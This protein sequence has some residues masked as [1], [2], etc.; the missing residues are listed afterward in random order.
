LPELF[1]G[2]EKPAPMNRIA[3][4]PM[5]SY[6]KCTREGFR[7]R[8]AHLLENLLE[9]NKNLHFVSI[10]RPEPLLMRKLLRPDLRFSLNASNFEY[11][12]TYSKKIPKITDRQQWWIKSRDNY[13][14]IDMC[15]YRG[16][17][18][19]NPLLAISNQSKALFNSDKPILFDVLDDWSIH[20]SFTRVRDNIELAYKKIFELS[21]YITANSEATVELS[22]RFGRSDVVLIPNGVEPKNFSTLSRADGNPKVGYI[23]K[24]GSRVDFLSVSEVVI[25]NP[26]VDFWFA[27]PNLGQNEIK[28][29]T[30]H[31]NFKWFGDIHYSEIPKFLEKLDLAWIPH[32]VGD[33]EVG[34]DAI[35]LYEYRAAG[36]PVLTSPI[37]GVSNR[38]LSQVHVL[39]IGKH[40]LFIKQVFE[41]QKRV[42]R[43]IESIAIE[44]QWSYKS[45]QMMTIL[46]GAN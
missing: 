34:G 26:N 5:H 17:I 28:K 13:P 12:E 41:S 4:F 3:L 43:I 10:S 44:N 37:I 8:D 20:N 2:I 15:E 24:L 16:A 42:P 39:P 36:L 21:T 32:F 19:W 18:V 27:G 1:A 14:Q 40:S 30:K 33:G 35:K 31:K 7:T 11:I 29:L 23:G 6:S 38:N 46:N 45:L 25:D 22:K 9:A